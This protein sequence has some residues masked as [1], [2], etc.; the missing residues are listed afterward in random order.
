MCGASLSSRT[1]SIRCAPLLPCIIRY[2]PR[3]D[4]KAL[5]GVSDWVDSTQTLVPGLYGRTSPWYNLNC[6]KRGCRFC[7]PPESRNPNS[8]RAWTVT[9][10]CSDHVAERS[11]LLLRGDDDVYSSKGRRRIVALDRR[12]GEARK[13][14]VLMAAPC[15]SLGDGS[16][17][18]K[19][20]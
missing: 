15:T 8:V 13:L 11:L 4:R 1:H 18:R 9:L 20:Q 19:R 5:S 7:T 17:G 6:T 12:S 16:G 3:S 10:L 2:L 14:V